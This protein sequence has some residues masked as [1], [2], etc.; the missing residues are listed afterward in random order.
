MPTQLYISNEVNKHTATFNVRL[1][2]K[3][4]KEKLS[5]VGAIYKVE[6]PEDEVYRLPMN[7]DG[8]MFAILLEAMMIG[9]DLFIHGPVSSAALRNAALFC[10]AWH[11]MMPDTYALI[12]IEAA[13]IIPNHKINPQNDHAISAFSGG[14]DGI[15]SALRHTAKDL[16]TGSHNLTHVLM[17][18]GLDIP[19][20]NIEGFKVLQQRVAPIYQSLGLK[21]I[22][23]WTN[24]RPLTHQHWEM[25]FSAQLAACLHLLSGSFQYGII[26]SSE[27]YSDMVLPWGSNPATNYLLSGASMEMVHDGAGY[28]RTEKVKRVSKHEPGVKFAKFCW[29]GEPGKNCGIC[30]KCIRTRLN[31]LAAVNEAHPACFDQPFELDKIEA[32]TLKNKAIYTEFKSILRYA[33][34]HHR[35]G[36]WMD[37][38]RQLVYRHMPLYDDPDNASNEIETS[39]PTKKTLLQRLFG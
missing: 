25:S 2:G 33:D 4:V 10:E 22:N 30:E 18:H 37:K 9:D 20:D 3:N 14:I 11:N 6:L 23:V 38:L 27:P 19:S 7:V 32:L 12:N 15:F 21:K 24:M 31:F 5:T 36:P 28:T 34:R 35:S 39:S 1:T 26:G 29:E 8:F 13:S 16:G 17:V